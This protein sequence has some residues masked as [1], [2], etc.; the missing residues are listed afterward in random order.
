MVEFGGVFNCID[1]Y[2]SILLRKLDFYDGMSL[3]AVLGL[4]FA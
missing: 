3:R 2:S 1:L 4:F